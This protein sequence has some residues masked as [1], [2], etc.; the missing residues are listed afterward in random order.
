VKIIHFK[1]AKGI[2]S[3]HNGMNIYRGCTHG[4]IYCD[5]RSNCYQIDHAFE[6]IEVKSN[7]PQLLEA[8]L[9]KK[10]SKCVISTGAMCDPYIPLENKLRHMRKCL[11]IIDRYGFG[12]AV[13]TKSTGVLRDIDLFESINSKAKSIV[14]MT[15]TTYNEDLC[16][17]IEPNVST[18]KQRFEALKTLH[19]AG[20][21]TVVWLCPLLPFI[22]DTKENLLGILDYCAKAKVYG[23]IMWNI[24]TTMRDGSREYFYQNLD[25]YFPGLSQKYHQKYGHSYEIT[26]DNSES[27][28]QLLRDTCEK[29]GIVHNRRAV[30][31]YMHT[32]PNNAPEQIKLF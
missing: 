7:A 17:I 3:A 1:E 2:L 30:F 29:H 19:E 10:R 26:S 8:A 24:G 22:N 13:L 11:E 20:I 21:P 32:L 9:R 15:L 12:A 27:L 31:Q 5:S 23:I 18:T 16:K 25:K 14:Q 4:C 6:D 28:M